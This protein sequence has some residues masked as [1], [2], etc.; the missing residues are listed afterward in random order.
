[1][2][3]PLSETALVSKIILRESRF[4]PRKLS[5]LPQAS[6][7]PAPS[8][9]QNSA[10]LPQI[11][12]GESVLWRTSLR[13]RLGR[14]TIAK[15]EANCRFDLRF[16]ESR[17]RLTVPLIKFDIRRSMLD[18]RRLFM[19]SGQQILGIRFF[20]GDVDE[21]VASM[22]Q[23]GGFLVAPS[24]T[25]FARLREDEVYRRAV[26][27]GDLA[28]ADSGLMVVL[29]RLFRRERVQRIS[30]LK[31]LKRLL[32]RLKGEGTTDV[33]WVLPTKRAEQK[34]LDWSRGAAFT[35][36]SENCYVA[37]RYG[38]EVGDQNLV[39][40]LEQRRAAH[41]II[42]IGSGAQEKLGYNLRENLS[43]LPAIH[44]IG[45]ALGFITGHQSAIPNWADRFYL[46]WFFRL[47]AQPSIFIPRL[48]RA[49]ELPWLI[50]K[51]GEKLPP[52]RR[53]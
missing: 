26:L 9:Q 5:G 40:L 28:I 1:V 44:C 43:Y 30:G 45:A 3:D 37:P 50:W 2:V 10:A 33:F 13:Q 7:E 51:Y 52:M 47:L 32:A 53:G 22:F 17:G 25:C 4:Q 39:G 21:A 46:G 15:R 49:L 6:N 11:R 31:Y 36:T 41:V 42:A 34:L 12:H 23:R 24:G 35:I 20:N 8:A 16:H 38:S 19:A 18:V 27:A 29:W 48:S 14:N